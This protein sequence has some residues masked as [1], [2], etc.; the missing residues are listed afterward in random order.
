MYRYEIY[1]IDGTTI[2]FTSNEDIDFKMLSTCADGTLTFP[3]FIVIMRN[4]KYIKKFKTT[5]PTTE[6]SKIC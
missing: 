6:G 1:F 3:D 2:S 5:V 4:V